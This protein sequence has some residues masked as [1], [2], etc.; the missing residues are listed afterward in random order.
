MCAL[1]ALTEH[2]LGPWCARAPVSK[3]LRLPASY[4]G[5][6]LHSGPSEPWEPGLFSGPPTPQGSTAS[7][8]AEFGSEFGRPS[9]GDSYRRFCPRR[10]TPSARTQTPGP[11]RAQAELREA[12]AASLFSAEWP[13]KRGT[14]GFPPAPGGVEW[15]CDAQVFLLEAYS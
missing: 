4:C 7:P 14:C 8:D 11:Q 5:P 15:P 1:R 3:A 13:R 12:S 10:A 9:R 2:A 6:E